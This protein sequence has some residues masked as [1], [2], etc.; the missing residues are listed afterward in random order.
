[1]QRDKITREKAIARIQSQPADE[2]YISRCD[3]TVYNN[4]DVCQLKEN[5]ESIFGGSNEI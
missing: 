1:M 5:L 4:S 2:F 3:Y